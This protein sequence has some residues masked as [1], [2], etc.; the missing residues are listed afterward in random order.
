[1]DKGGRGGNR[2]TGEGAV[3][4]W[5]VCTVIELKTLFVLLTFILTAN[6]I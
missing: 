5:N 1:M 4:Y 2:R 6:L 3:E